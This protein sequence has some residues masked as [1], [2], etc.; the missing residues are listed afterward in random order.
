MKTIKFILFITV[1]CF[2]LLLWNKIS[3]YAE[4]NNFENVLEETT[5]SIAQQVQTDK[6]HSEWTNS[7]TEFIVKKIVINMAIPLMIF[8]WVL[9]TILWAY[10][11]IMDNNLDSITKW[12]NYFVWWAIWTILMIWA[13]FIADSFVNWLLKTW[14]NQTFDAIFLSKWLYNDILYPFLRL[15]LYVWI[16]VLFILLLISVF[17]YFTTEDNERKLINIMI[18]NVIWILVIMWAKQLIEA[19]YWKQEEVLNTDVTNLWQIWPGFFT[20]KHVEIIYHIIQR[21]MWMWAL[22]IVL[23][24]ISLAFKL[25]TNPEDWWTIDLIKK[26]LLYSFLWVLVV[27]AGYILVNFVIIN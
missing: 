2:A 26:Y 8:V 14:N 15:A 6:I 23:L 13:K 22:L 5:Q 21:I 10:Y 17:K 7:I 20:H 24:L 9:F 16:G 12:S 27:W 11:L 4:A 19:V 3:V 1:S 25:L 18:S